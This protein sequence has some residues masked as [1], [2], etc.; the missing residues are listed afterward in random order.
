MTVFTPF[1]IKVIQTGTALR[2]S[3]LRDP[4]RRKLAAPASVPVKEH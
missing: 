3:S 2:A 4:K 1:T